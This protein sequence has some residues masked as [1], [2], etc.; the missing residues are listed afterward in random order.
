MKPTEQTLVEQMRISDLELA[1]RKA[2]LNFSQKDVDIIRDRKSDIEADLAEIVDEFYKNQTEINEVVLLIGDADT[3][4]RLRNAQ[5]IYILDLFSGN[6]DIEYANR[7][8]RIGL[9]HKRIGV[10]PK[11]YLSATRTLHEIIMKSIL[12]HVEESEKIKDI[13]SAL[14]KL[15][16]FDVTLVFDAYIGSMLTEIETGKQNLESYAKDLEKK[17]VERTSELEE[18]SRKDALTGLFNLRVLKET[19]QH[20]MRYSERSGL[21]LSLVYFDV[22]SFKRIND[23]K[24]HQ[25]GDVILQTI[26]KI[27]SS[28]SR[29]I[30]TACRYGGDEFC[31]I[32]PG[33]DLKAGKIYCERLVESL[34]QENPEISISIGLAQTGPTNFVSMEALI[35]NADRNMYNAK[36]T[37]GIYIV[38]STEANDVQDIDRLSA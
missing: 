35:K 36:R 21:P 15:F 32:L 14:D 16:Y 11:L 1:H 19:L 8:L 10:E 12:R 26:G 31:V 20:D 18:L 13:F 6:Y 7:R 38:A 24:G 23:G 17:I 4:N 29:D 25:Y 30:D 34:K 2:L 22:D 5:R 33:A 9:V 37:E 27:L 3:L 28:V